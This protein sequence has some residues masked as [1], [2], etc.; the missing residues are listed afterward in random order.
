MYLTIFTVNF[1]CWKQ[2]LYLS[3]H[4]RVMVVVVVVGIGNQMVVVLAF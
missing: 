1:Y 3:I 4:N 2:R